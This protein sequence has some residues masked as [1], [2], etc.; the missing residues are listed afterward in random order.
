MQKVFVGI[1]GLLVLYLATANARL[2]SQG[3]VLNERLAAAEK[4]VLRIAPAKGVLPASKLV[5]ATKEPSVDPSESSAGPQVDSP[6][7]APVG[8]TAAV[9][10]PAEFQG[11]KPA[12]EP[13]QLAGKSLT[14]TLKDDQATLV[15]VGG[16]E[17]LGLTQAQ[18]KAVAELR[19]NGETQT[20]AY[21]DMILRIEAQTEQSIRQLL[22][23]E[24]LAKYDAQ[25]PAVVGETTFDPAEEPRTASGLKQGYLGISGGDAE[26]GG[27]RVT[28]VFPNTA[29]SAL[30]LQKD[31]VILEFN[32]ETIS[33]LAALSAKI[34]ESGEGFPVVLRIRRGGNDIFQN[35]QLGALPK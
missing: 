29:A 27:A 6:S 24:Q 16:D 13:L 12:S 21:T 19:K 25:H 7:A 26:G 1:L 15:R 22:S 28:Q 23:P 9:I 17:D 10:N 35:V 11:S 5:P 8:S 18:Q 3:R 34:K 31:D 20:Q 33:N 14:F 30:G 2:Q 4:K 32:G